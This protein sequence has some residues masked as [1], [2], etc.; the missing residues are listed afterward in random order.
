MSDVVRPQFKYLMF[1]LLIGIDGA[2][3]L[4]N[5]IDQ[6]LGALGTSYTFHGQ[7]VDRAHFNCLG[8]GATGNSP[9]S[10]PMAIGRRQTKWVA[11]GHEIKDEPSD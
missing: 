6:R 10:V 5:Y 1:A 2:Y 7:L 3:V 8:C 4:S 11:T 9:V